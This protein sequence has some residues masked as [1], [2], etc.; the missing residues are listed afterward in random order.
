MQ[1]TAGAEG[2]S[3]GTLRWEST[4][5]A[6]EIKGGLS[7]AGFD[8]RVSEE[9]ALYETAH[10]TVHLSLGSAGYYTGSLQPETVT[11]AQTDPMESLGRLK[12][13]PQPASG[14][15]KIQFDLPSHARVKVEVF[16][17]Q[18][19][20]VRDLPAMELAAGS[21]VVTWDGKDAKGKSVSTGM[22]FVRVMYGSVER[23][24]RLVIS[25]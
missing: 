25:R 22:Y 16:D 17:V 11:G 12:I 8:V 5:V 7:Q 15:I 19:R 10:W 21:Q 2:D 3:T 23:F 4:D 24:G 18:G 1:Y 13:S 14:V 9:D 6:N 20:L